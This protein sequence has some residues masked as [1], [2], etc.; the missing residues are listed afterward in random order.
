MSLGV[1]TTK[2]R[3]AELRERAR[4]KVG[5]AQAQAIKADTREII[6]NEVVNNQD[7]EPIKENSSI[8]A[9]KKEPYL[10]NNWKRCED[11][12]IINEIDKRGGAIWQTATGEI[13]YRFSLD[14][15]IFKTT[16]GKASNVI[17]SY[18]DRHISI[19][20]GNNPD[21]TPKDLKLIESEEFLPFEPKEFTDG[22]QLNK[23]RPTKF[24]MLDDS[25]YN[26]PTA[27]LRLIEH[28]TKDDKERAKWIVNWLAGFFQTLRKSQV[29]LVLRGVQGAGKGI[30][31][32]RVIRPLFGD[33]HAIQINDKTL[34]TNFLGGIVEGRLFYNLDEISHSIGTSKQIKNFIKAL[35]TNDRLSSEKKNVNLERETPLYGQV[36]ITSNEPYI[37]EVEA[38]DRRF[39]VYETG[40]ALS[41]VDFLGYRDYHTLQSYIDRELKDFAK[42]LKAYK[43]DRTLYNQAQD[44]I[45]KQ[46][47]INSTSDKFTLFANAIK[48]KDVIFF[49]DASDHYRNG[50]I[51]D[52][53]K[54][55]ICKEDLRGMFNSIFEDENISGKKLM[56]KLR[57]INPALFDDSNISKSSG[58]HYFRL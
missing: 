36:L 19:F 38:S 24:M 17:G 32:D 30:L 28:L 10:F 47:L 33:N 54:N 20:S 57:A 31:F 21:I 7:R 43:V 35:V 48:N 53:E 45:E 51:A 52:F 29:S 15:T 16:Q 14:G 3:V 34:Q 4:A 18:L 1:E 40:E 41:K 50:V 42:Y 9:G 56:T 13:A 8:L 46:A 58:Q 27:I 55:R 22:G 5:T 25:G 37:I 12:D 11:N 6:P 49:D 2:A 39:T 44:T 26:E 23:F